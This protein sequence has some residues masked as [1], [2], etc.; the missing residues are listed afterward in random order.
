MTL[1]PWVSTLI[2]SAST[3]ALRRSASSIFSLTSA[4]ET[5]GVTLIDWV[6]RQYHLRRS[7]LLSEQFCLRQPSAA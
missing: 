7:L 5:V 4:G 2:L 1:P 3:S 6:D